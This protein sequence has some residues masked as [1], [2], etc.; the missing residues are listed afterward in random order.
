MRWSGSQFA[1]FAVIAIAAGV[2]SGGPV[3]ASRAADPVETDTILL[4]RDQSGQP[5]GPTKFFVSVAATSGTARPTGTVTVK[6]D[7]DTK[8][9]FDLKKD[10]PDDDHAWITDDFTVDLGI[11]PH[12]FI[13][14]YQ[15]NYAFAASDDEL[16]MAVATMDPATPEPSQ[17]GQSVTYTYV[18]GIWPSSPR[19]PTG[20]VS[21]SDDDGHTSSP[22][23]PTIGNDLK[24]TW[25]VS[26]RGL[27]GGA[28]WT[29]TANY[30][31]D[32]FYLNPKPV[33]RAHNVNAPPP[34]APPATT[35][36]TRKPTV[37]TRRTT[38]TTRRTGVT[39]A[40]APINPS[41]TTTPGQG[42]STTVTFGS[43]PTSPPITTDLSA[44]PSN[45]NND[46][47][48]IAVVVTT[49]LALGVL[50]GIAAFR[51]YRHSA[52]DWF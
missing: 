38:A 48:P 16:G 13:T 18:L 44:S 3:P 11:A 8:G 29:T 47:P 34:G 37:T 21:F 43:F 17:D 4:W 42:S 15:G 23:D 39:S 6:I 35:T 24:A 27:T 41:S 12:Y 46:G 9:P 10:D 7:S 50:G 30:P 25:I 36:S 2:L 49:L 22:N 45:Q 40:L 51:R 52:V 20:K 28:R 14:K 26:Q 5:T 1:R 33:S 19:K 31:G 32:D